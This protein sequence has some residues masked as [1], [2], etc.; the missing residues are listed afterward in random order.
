V[1]EKAWAIFAE[2]AWTELWD[3]RTEPPETALREM[4]EMA[5]RADS[6]DSAEELLGIEGNS[7]RL[8]FGAFD[9]MLK[10]GDAAETPEGFRLDF[11]GR[12]RRPPRD[13]VNA[14]LSLG[15][16]MLAKDLTI[17]CYAVGFDP[18]ETEPS[19]RASRATRQAAT[20]AFVK[21]GRGSWMDSQAK[22][23][24]SP[25]LKTRLVIGEET[26]SSTRDF[27]LYH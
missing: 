16:S 7:A 22:N 15:Y 13:P 26:L 5:L 2:A 1:V 19:P 6:A 10:A 23:S 24:S 21:P 18:M 3:N 9:G 4:K 20:V 12:Y 27:S 14:L 8:Y 25:R 11:E 17:A